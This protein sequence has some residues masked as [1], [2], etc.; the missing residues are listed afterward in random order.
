MESIVNGYPWGV[1][2]VR[3]G[4][5]SLHSP[6]QS[7]GLNSTTKMTSK[8]DAPTDEIISVKENINIPGYRKHN[9]SSF[10]A[11]SRWKRFTDER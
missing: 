5:N 7:Q 2:W 1:S 4:T 9:K 8:L 11:K 10:S 3:H 6:E